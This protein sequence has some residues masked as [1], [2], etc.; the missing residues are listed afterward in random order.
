MV[1]FGRSLFCL[2]WDFLIHHLFCCLNHS[3]F[4]SFGLVPLSLGHISITSLKSP[5]LLSG[6]TRC[7]WRTLYFPYP[8]SGSAISLRCPGTLC[9][10]MAFRNQDLET[11]YACCYWGV[12]VL[13]GQLWNIYVCVVT[14]VHTHICNYFCI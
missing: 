7:C 12:A 5:F 9:W 13:S 3:S 10:R 14:H 6:M 1:M 4:G 2:L 8:F 11:G